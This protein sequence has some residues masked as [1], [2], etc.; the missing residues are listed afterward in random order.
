[1]PIVNHFLERLKVIEMLES[2]LSPGNGRSKLKLS[3]TLGVLLR[4]LIL[5]RNEIQEISERSSDNGMEIVNWLIDGNLWELDKIR[6]QAEMVAET[7]CKSM[8]L[9]HPWIA[10]NFEESLHQ[11]KSFTEILKMAKDCM[12]FLIEVSRETGVR[13]LFETHGGALLASPLAAIMLFDGASPQNVGVIYDPANTIIEG[14]LRPRSE[15]EV[16]GGYLAYL[17]AKNVVS[18]FNRIF[19]EPVGRTSWDIKAVPPD[20]GMLDWMEVLFALKYSGFKGFI[21]SE[22]YFSASDIKSLKNGVSFL[23]KCEQLAPSAVEQPY[24]TFNNSL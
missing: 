6:A 1:M 7:N 15:V 19:T 8:R 22:E 21:S 2:E 23:R 11:E 4:N 3:R 13:F 5:K 14:N 18:Y 24:T 12:P 9:G 20:S 16:L 17:H 10:Y